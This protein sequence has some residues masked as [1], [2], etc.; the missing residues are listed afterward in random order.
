MKYKNF[1]DYLQWKHADQYHGLDDDMPDD[2]QSW[3]DGLSVDEWIEYGTAYGV[4]VSDETRMEDMNILLKN[5]I[6]PCKYNHNTKDKASVRKCKT[7]DAPLCTTASCGYVVSGNNY[8]NECYEKLEREDYG[9][10]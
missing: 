9:N 8:C 1:E 5:A 4:I 7:C 3:L 2:Y 6:E 10:E